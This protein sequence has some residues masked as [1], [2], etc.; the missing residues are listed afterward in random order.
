MRSFSGPDGSRPVLTL[1][2]RLGGAAALVLVGLAVILGL[3]ALV[4]GPTSGATSGWLVAGS[5]TALWVAAVVLL[6]LHQERLSREAAARL[7]A[8]ESSTRRFESL[9]RDSTDLLLVT[10]PDGNVVYCSPASQRILG[11]APEVVVGHPVNDL[12][13][14]SDWPI[15]LEGL[16][17]LAETENAELTLELHVRHTDG[18]HR[19][20]ESR[21]RNPGAGAAVPGLVWS[22]R[23]VTERRALEQELNHRVMHDGLTRVPNRALLLERLDRALGRAERHDA[24]V[25]VV[26]V[27]LN[28]LSTVNENLGHAAGDEVVIAAAAR[29][30]AAVRAE[31]TVARLGGGE[32]AL[33]LEEAADLDTV[34]GVTDRGLALLAEPIEA[35]GQALLLTA[36]AGIALNRTAEAFDGP[37]GL[38]R[39]AQAAA[40]LASGGD[41]PRYLVFEESM[42]EHAEDWSDLTA[43]IRAATHTGQIEVLYQPL[44][45]LESGELEGFEALA[46]WQHPVRGLVP[47]STFIPVAEDSGAIHDIGR[48]VLETACRQAASWNGEGPGLLRMSVNVSPFQLA[49]DDI[50]VQVREALT[51]TGLPAHQLILEMTESALVHDL[52]SVTRR[53]QGLRVMGVRIA[54][55]DFGTGYSSLAYLRRLPL[56]IVKIDKSFVD[57]ERGAGPE[58][59]SSVIAMGTTLGLDTVAEGIED[60]EQLERARLAGCTYGQGYLIAR[61]M[62]AAAATRFVAEHAQRAAAYPA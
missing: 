18:S 5:V 44:I 61:P 52:T 62:D 15:V 1:V 58:L 2:G 10:G 3:S 43:D 30:Q 60:P 4:G 17:R 40:Y 55:D 19:T 13:Q 32:F 25:A 16:E 56:D 47:P 29:L 45:D 39:D 36:S 20:L 21:V 14:S 31:D 37:E 49:G 41:A 24:L 50:L 7:L 34:V 35:A 54:M 57:D 26:L 9:L 28:D 23:D 22:A 11:V 42:R 8:Q 46:R 12:V 51:V 59:L 27:C 38:L 6:L 53:L 48:H 33:L